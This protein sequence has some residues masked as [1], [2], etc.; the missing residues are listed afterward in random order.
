MEVSASTKDINE[1][2]NGLI[3]FLKSPKVLRKVCVPLYNVCIPSNELEIE[4]LGKLG[5]AAARVNDFE[6]G[7]RE[8]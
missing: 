2:L 7:A 8:I 1:H 6:T 5:V 4:G 3:A